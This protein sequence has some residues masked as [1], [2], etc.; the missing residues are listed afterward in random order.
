MEYEGCRKPGGELVKDQDGCAGSAFRA[1]WEAEEKVRERTDEHGNRW[2]KV[3][4]GGGEH[5]KG[6]LE[7]CRELGEVM[8]EEIDAGPYACFAG[9]GEKLYRIWVRIDPEKSEDLW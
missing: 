3:Y 9:A 2:R 7:Q 4:V 5:F 8:V 1:A 6:W